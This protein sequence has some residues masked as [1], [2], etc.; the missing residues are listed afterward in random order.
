MLE[1]DLD[2]NSD[3]IESRRN[4]HHNEIEKLALRKHK[5]KNKIA[6]KAKIIQDDVK[7]FSN[8]SELTKRGQKQTRSSSQDSQTE[9]SLSYTHSKTGQKFFFFQNI[10]L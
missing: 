9:L 5:S 3:N 7:T 6:R 4:S 10:V 2:L 8:V 1:I